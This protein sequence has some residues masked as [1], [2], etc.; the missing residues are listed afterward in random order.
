MM[1]FNGQIDSTTYQ[2][3]YITFPWLGAL[4]A[5]FAY[6]CIFRRAETSVE[7]RDEA[8]QE[9]HDEHKEGEEALLSSN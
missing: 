6:E 4:I 5:V 1:T 9:E 3:I 7:H 2:W 8:M